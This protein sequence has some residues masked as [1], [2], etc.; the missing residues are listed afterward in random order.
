MANQRQITVA[1]GV[2]YTDVNASNFVHYAKLWQDGTRD[3]Q[4]DYK[5]SND[6]FTAVYIIQAGDFI[7]LV[8]HGRSGALAVPIHANSASSPTIGGVYIKLH[9]TDGAS[10]TVNVL[11]SESEL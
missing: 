6:N 8:G 11:E 9:A 2:G 4:I 3:R 10:M 5:L 7:E 1:S